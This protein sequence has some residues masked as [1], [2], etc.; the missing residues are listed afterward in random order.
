MESINECVRLLLTLLLSLSSSSSTSLYMMSVM[1][2]SCIAAGH[3]Y[4]TTREL[5]FQL[6]LQLLDTYTSKPLQLLAGNAI[7][8]TGR[9][10]VL[11]TNSRVIHMAIHARIFT[12]FVICGSQAHSFDHMFLFFEG[13]IELVNGIERPVGN[14]GIYGN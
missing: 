3:I 5:L 2:M 10:V 8:T 12:I 7:G 1:S 14:T 11:P 4:V 13:S 9:S 6:L